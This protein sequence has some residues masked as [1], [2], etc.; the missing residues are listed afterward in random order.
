MSNHEPVPAGVLSTGIEAAINGYLNGLG[1]ATHLPPLAWTIDFE[2]D[3]E[4]NGTHPDGRDH[5]DAEA[6]CASWASLLGLTEYDFDP[7][8]G[9]RSW[10]R[11][12]QEWHLKFSAITD[13]ELY[14]SKIP[15]DRN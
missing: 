5:P 8:D 1:E 7:G 4:I 6:L 9:F 2:Y 12:L 11:S 3:P 10:Q 13:I 14:R 15:G